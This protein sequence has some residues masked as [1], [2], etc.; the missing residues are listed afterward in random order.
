MKAIYKSSLS[1]TLTLAA[2]TVT[3]SLLSACGGGGVANDVTKLITGSIT[4]Q[5][6]GTV[7]GLTGTGLVLEDNGGNSLPVSGNGPFTFSSQ[8]SNGAAYAVTVATQP[9]NPAQ[10]CSVA[11]GTGTIAT[12]NVSN[13]TVACVAAAATAQG[14]PTGQAVTQSIGPAGGSITSGDGRLT[15][16]VP[17]GAIA[18]ATTLSIQPI[19][20]LTPGGMGSAYRLGP[21]GTT[22]L[23]PVSIAFQYGTA[24]LAGTNADDMM[25]AFQDA[26]GYWEAQV[27]ATLDTTHQTLTAQSSHF[28]DWSLLTGGQLTPAE[29]TVETGKTVVLTFVE[30]QPVQDG[31]QV[32]RLAA[33]TSQTADAWSVN[34]ILN[35]NSAVGYVGS[36]GGES[37]TATY[38]APAA[39]PSANPVAVSTEAILVGLGK[40]RETFVSNIT[41]VSPCTAPATNCT[42]T[43]TTTYVGELRSMTTQ[44]TW[45]AVSDDM[46]VVQVELVSGTATFATLQ[47]GCTMDL[48]TEAI[49]P[50]D[51]ESGDGWVISLDSTPVGYYGMAWL[52]TALPSETCPD[53]SSTI[54]FVWSP[55]LFLNT[56]PPTSS[57]LPTSSS[58]SSATLSGTYTD[59]LG[60]WTWNMRRTQ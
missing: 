24:D 38:T 15:V 42:W 6:G 11:N 23:T 52:E 19:T 51:L 55:V 39:V 29:A 56:G 27:S 33:C 28:S 50:A 32:T 13:V 34:S 35:G 59:S 40:T 20:N 8:L 30:C 22:F 36:S 45:R 58:P 7:S 18:S 44:T 37:A 16:T 21:E 49:A 60:T 17:A 1:K 48:T 46:G 47:P 31:D 25:I 57:G 2:L 53:N 9:T 5:V 3:S 10:S 26:Q 41:V 12:A 14:T 4:Y 43:G 54:T